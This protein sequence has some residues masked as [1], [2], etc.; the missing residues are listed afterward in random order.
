[1][2]IYAQ[3]YTPWFGK[4]EGR[5][6]RSWIIAKEGIKIALRNRWAQR[7]V[8]FA[9]MITAGYI[10]F[11]YLF[12]NME[13][14]HEVGLSVGNRLYKSY[15]RNELTALLVMAITA[16]VGCGLISRDLKSNAISM[17]FSR[18]ISR[19]EY[20]LG[21]LLVNIFYLSMITAVPLFALLVANIGFSREKAELLDH[22]KDVGAIMLSS[23]AIVL[24]ASL[25]AL[26][27]SSLT[28][29]VYLPSIL[30]AALF[31]GS[32]VISQL[33]YR[34][35]NLE[36]VKLLSFINNY[37]HFGMLMFEDRPLSSILEYESEG[38]EITRQ[39]FEQRIMDFGI[40]P[41]GAILLGICV[42]SLLVLSLRL[43]YV[44]SKE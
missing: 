37:S 16:F 5:A 4:A 9:L 26:G 36:W 13:V 38:S 6:K 25:L 35:T 43:R 7:V 28:K 40:L 18:A 27:L 34:S 23:L 20:I 22:L 42:I 31:Y 21:K 14:Q 32:H 41:T 11:I 12:M 2:A 39:I 10:F 19:H 30:W 24:P 44:Q 3:G 15:I 8:L 33:L 1:M 17:Y 29:I